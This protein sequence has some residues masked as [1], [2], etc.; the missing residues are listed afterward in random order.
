ML[1][2]DTML[3]LYV[4]SLH[5]FLASVL[6][7]IPPCYGEFTGS[8]LVIFKLTSIRYFFCPLQHKSISM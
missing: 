2:I 4:G 8:A 3:V 6:A 5:I 7:D 1:A